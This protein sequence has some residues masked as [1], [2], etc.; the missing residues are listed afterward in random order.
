MAQTLYL[1]PLCHTPTFDEQLERLPDHEP[2]YPV[3]RDAVELPPFLGV[4]EDEPSERGPVQL[5][6]LQ[7]DVRPEHPADLAP[8][9]PAGLHHWPPGQA[10]TGQLQRHSGAL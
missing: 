8:R 4:A 10:D 5:A 3:V 1:M 7:E 6:A 2:L 9:R